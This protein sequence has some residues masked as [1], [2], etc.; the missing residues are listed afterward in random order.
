MDD[1]ERRRRQADQE[2]EALHAL[3]AIMNGGDLSAE[4][5]RLSNDFTDRQSG[6]LAAWF[7]RRRDPMSGPQAPPI[8]PG[9]EQPHS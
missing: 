9:A 1:D 5:L 7:R 4:A 2:A 8:D 3:E 6:G